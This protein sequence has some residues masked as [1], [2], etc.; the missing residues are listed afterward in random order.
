MVPLSSAAE[1]LVAEEG[2]AEQ[3]RRRH[4]TLLAGAV[5][6][7]ARTNKPLVVSALASDLQDDSG[8]LAQTDV[9]TCNAAWLDAL[10]VQVREH[11]SEMRR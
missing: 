4:A 6:R 1:P 11:V 5:A 8:T 2:K 7:A 10:A 9:Q 3:L